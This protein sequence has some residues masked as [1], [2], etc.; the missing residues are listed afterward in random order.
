MD[1]GVSEID[2]K[3]FFFS[4]DGGTNAENEL[5]A[6]LDAFFSAEVKDDNSSICRFPARYSWLEEKL[7]AYD[8]PTA[9]CP[10]YDK[11]FNRVDPKSVTLVFPSAHINSPAS[12]FGHT[13]LRINSSYNSKLL[14]YAINY[15]ASANADTE[16]GMV[17]AMKG[18]FGGYFGTYSL[19]PY[20]E[21]L[22]E[23][24]DSEQRDIWEYDLNLNQEET[25]RMFKHIWELNGTFSDY[26]FFTE[27]CSYNMLWFLE[28]AR[29]GLK[30]RDKFSYQVIPLETVHVA[31]SE[32]LISSKSYRPSKRTTLLTYEKLLKDDNVNI[33][34]DVIDNNQSMSSLLEVN[35]VSL[36]Q[37]RYILEA[38]VEYLEYQYSKGKVTKKRYLALF[39]NFTSQRAKLGLTKKIDVKTPANPIDSHQA[40][41][42]ELGGGVRDSEA[43][44]YL[45]FRFAYHDLEDSNYGFLRG[46]Q[47]EFFDILL[48]QQKDK[49]R[50]EK[51]TLISIVSLAQRS[52]FFKSLSWRTKIGWDRDSL[53]EDAAFY[54]GVGAGYSWGNELAYIYFLVDPFFYI[55]VDSHIGVGGS[56]GFSIDKYKFMNTNFEATQR[57]YETGDTQTLIKASQGF[58][59]SQN[60]QIMLKY[61]YKDRLVVSQK[62]VENS[63]GIMLK[64]YY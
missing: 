14:S 60:F 35:K 36:E 39:H 9:S 24:R 34:V 5:N 50:V 49:T 4:K 27:N 45:G 40:L 63:L 20:Y 28:A 32:N 54:G 17:F 12:M 13:F 21:K 43:I 42:V 3:N 30:L 52:D 47:I 53:S 41:R 6:T 62:E 57:I 61:D 18:L 19:L 59:V 56:V 23:Y 48:S 31:K 29:P 1:D 64:Y 2:D 26:Y 44:G 33:V 55:D 11:I 8:L 38:A 22:K 7:Q 58:R 46:T 51:A 15:A 10:Q 16:N 25:V 37:K